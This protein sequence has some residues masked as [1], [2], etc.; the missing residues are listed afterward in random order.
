MKPE[1]A[2]RTNRVIPFLKSLKGTAFFPIQQMTIRG[3]AD[4][5]LCCNGKFVWLELK[6]WG[7]PLRPLQ[8]YKADLVIEKGGIALR[9][10]PDNWEEIKALLNQLGG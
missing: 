5:I 4:F 1:T 10:S 9:C 2:F 6:D 8:K 7:Q 3:D